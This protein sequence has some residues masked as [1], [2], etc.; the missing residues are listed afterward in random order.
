MFCNSNEGL[1]HSMSD[2][3]IMLDDYVSNTMNE[4]ENDTLGEYNETVDQVTCFMSFHARLYTYNSKFAL[5][6]VKSSLSSRIT[7]L[8]QRVIQIVNICYDSC[9]L[10]NNEKKQFSIHNKTI[11]CFN[12]AELK[13]AVCD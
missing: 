11:Q 3:M 8:L 6:A 7:L 1:F 5:K 2:G 9:Y 4:L 10:T 13:N 12:F